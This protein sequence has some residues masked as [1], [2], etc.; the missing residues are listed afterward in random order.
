MAQG[1]SEQQKQQTQEGLL[2][3]YF[4]SDLKK[5]K[6]IS[7][8]C[9]SWLL[10]DTEPTQCLHGRDI[11][12]KAIDTHTQ[13]HTASEMPIQNPLFFF[14]TPLYEAKQQPLEDV[15]D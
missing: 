8:K 10:S 9:F 4:H 3:F 5:K 6:C 1:T 2:L 15:M 7:E 13:T 11:E 14:F 12:V